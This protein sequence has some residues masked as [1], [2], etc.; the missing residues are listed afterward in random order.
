MFYVH[1]FSI[2]FSGIAILELNGI[3]V[4]IFPILS[5]MP[6]FFLFQSFPKH[7]ICPPFLIFR[8][9]SPGVLPL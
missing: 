3:D 8:L 7:F 1:T 6:N 5:K 9:W 4:A 2:I